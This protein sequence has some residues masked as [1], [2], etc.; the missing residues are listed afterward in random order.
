MQQI[1]DFEK[2][3]TTKERALFLLEIGLTA[4]ED[5]VDNSLVYRAFSGDMKLPI[6]AADKTICIKKATKWLQEKT[7]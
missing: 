2:I 5:E 3:K 6:T 1:N 7:L 4:K